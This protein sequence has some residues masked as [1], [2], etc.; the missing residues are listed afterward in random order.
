[1]NRSRA[2]NHLTAGRTRPHRLAPYHTVLLSRPSQRSRRLNGHRLRID[3]RSV[4][5]IAIQSCS[6]VN[7]QIK[8]RSVVNRSYAA[9]HLT[10]VRPHRF[11]Q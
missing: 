9:N 3:A 2:A 8:A 7:I 5:Q 11:V 4:V 1:V 6:V 10:P